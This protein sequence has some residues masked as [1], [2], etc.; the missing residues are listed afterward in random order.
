VA[1]KWALLGAGIAGRARARAILA[2]PRGALAAVYR[3]RFAGELGAPQVGSM[4]AAIGAAEAVAV[5][6]PSEAHPAQVEAALRAGRHVAVEF[7]LAAG[8]AEAARLFALADE[9]GRVL[10]VEHIELLTG[11]AQALRGAREVRAV[12][13]AFQ[14][15]GPGG[16]PGGALALR[17]VARLHRLVDAAGPIARVG[18]VAASTD[19]LSATLEL[20][21][22][23]RASLAFRAGP[24]LARETRLTLEDARGRWEQVNGALT[25]DGA[26]VALPPSPGLFA[27]DHRQATARIL[28][29]APGYLERW[30]VLHVLEVAGMLREGRT[31]AVST[32]PQAPPRS[33]RGRA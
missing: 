29:G 6:S 22:G 7:P 30:R 12:S 17:N 1:L 32:S 27:E 3:G 20:A 11:T 2:D 10:H 28:D 13:V 4:E 18:A 31:G 14:G 9:V 25:L 8:A 33:P 24:G 5:C 26:P 16:E 23:A 15:R 19:A 21:C